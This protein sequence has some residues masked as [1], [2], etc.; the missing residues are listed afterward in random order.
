L[1]IDIK[2]SDAPL[3][4]NILFVRDYMYTMKAMASLVFY[5]MM[6]LDNGKII[7]QDQLNSMSEE[8]LPFSH[9]T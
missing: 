1:L 3:D 6:F 9:L 4:F 7:A 8:H 2:V 5:T